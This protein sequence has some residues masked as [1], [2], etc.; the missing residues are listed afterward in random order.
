MCRHAKA[1]PAIQ[2]AHVVA[3]EKL[4]VLW[5]MTAL[6][7]GDCSLYISYDV[8]KSRWLQQYVKIT[9]MPSCRKQ[10]SQMVDIDIPAALPAGRAIPR[11]DWRALH[12][13]PKVEFYV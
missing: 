5:D 10:D 3:G 11:W 8:N 1:N 2:P 7:V 4:G 13:F 12:R 6:H 9:N